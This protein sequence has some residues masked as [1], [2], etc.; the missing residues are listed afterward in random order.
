MAE[1]AENSFEKHRKNFLEAFDVLVDKA[2]EE[3]ET[4]PDLALP[5]QWVRKVS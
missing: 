5:C 3:E 4:I 1:K 2:V